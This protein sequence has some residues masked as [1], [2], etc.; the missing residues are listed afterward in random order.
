MQP[1]RGRMPAILREVWGE[2]LR[3]GP[4]GTGRLDKPLVPAPEGVLAYGHRRIGTYA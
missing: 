4:L 2:R 3:P 1:V